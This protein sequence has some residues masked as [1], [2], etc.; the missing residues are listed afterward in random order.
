LSTL[1]S[2]YRSSTNVDS[3]F[4]SNMENQYD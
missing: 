3:Y 2:D 1:Y 4:S